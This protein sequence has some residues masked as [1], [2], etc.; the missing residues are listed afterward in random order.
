[1]ARFMLSMPDEM[2]KKLDDAA[3]RE[4]R[5][6]SELLREA[7]RRHLIAEMASDAGQNSELR[8]KR[9]KA[10]STSRKSPRERLLESGMGREGCS[11]LERLLGAVEDSVDMHRVLKIGQKLKGLSRQIIDSRED[12]W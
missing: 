5:S 8:V 3:R 4:H 9:K 11:G 12:R 1:M 6:R 2:L 10:R 7:A